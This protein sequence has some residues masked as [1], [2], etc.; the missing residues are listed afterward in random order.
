VNP[1]A[2]VV[3]RKGWTRLCQG[4][5]IVD[6][7]LLLGVLAAL[8]ALA[9]PSPDRQHLP[10][11]PERGLALQTRTGV[12]LESMQ[13]RRLA[14]LKGLFLAPEKATSHG[15]FLL[16]RR[17]RLFTLDLNAGRIRRAYEQPSRFKGCRLTDARFRLELLVC[18]HTVKT[19][20]YRP[21]AKPTLRVVAR[22]PGRIG[23]WQRASFAPRG[24]AFFAQ[25]SAECEVPV[26]FLVAAGR[27][28]P[29]GGTTLRD[30]PSSVALGW[31]PNGS[32]VVHFPQ[33][34]CGGAFRTPG[35]YVIR[36]AGRT[37][38]LLRTPHFASYL[39]WGG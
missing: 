32:V 12:E 14:L 3:H 17:G 5:T 13:G 29:Y 30:A 25:W 38:L 15:L 1:C 2:H 28:R 10:S 33:G 31:L 9:A 26:A 35:I 8:A 18:G 4:I 23:H 39:M 21:G 36:R 34:A 11:L 20:L 27:M 22:A 24:S 37:Q 6:M 19:A 16:D 7:R